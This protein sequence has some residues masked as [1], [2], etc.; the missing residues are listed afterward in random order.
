MSWDKTLISI[1]SDDLVW[2]AAVVKQYTRRMLTGQILAQ[3]FPDAGGQQL[4]IT[5][6]HVRSAVKL[7]DL[8][9]EET[10]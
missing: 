8:I 3:T 6:A 4:N 10:P 2:A 5:A 7:A 9:I 1:D